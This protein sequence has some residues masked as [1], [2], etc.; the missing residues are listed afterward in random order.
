MSEDRFELML[1]ESLSGPEPRLGPGF[2]GRLMRKLEQKS[3]PMSRAGW[4]V[5]GGYGLVSVITCW[6][7][8]VGQQIDGWTAGGTITAAAALNAGLVWALGRRKEPL[9]NG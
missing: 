7:V 6:V 1:W 2:E 5:F 9:S 3:Q 8:M 4:V